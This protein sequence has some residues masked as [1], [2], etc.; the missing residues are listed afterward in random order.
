MCLFDT[1][2]TLIY[3]NSYPRNKIQ[4]ILYLENKQFDLAF[5]GSSRTENNIDCEV[6]EKITGKSCINLGMAGASMGDIYYLMKLAKKYNLQFDQVYLQLDYNYNHESLETTPY[7]KGILA[8]YHKSLF[9]KSYIPD[10]PYKDNMNLYP[11]YRY[12]KND[13]VIGF[14]EII[15]SSFNKKAGF[16]PQ[17]GF[18]PQHGNGLLIQGNLP[19]KIIKNN[20]A[21]EKMKIIFPI[22]TKFNLFTAPYCHLVNNREFI[23]RLKEQEP[24]LYNFVR[25]FDKK[26][27]Y[28][29]NC[30]HLNEEGAKEFSKILGKTISK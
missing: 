30:G 21:I 29:S 12:M 16:N 18:V 5:F 22:K 10:F 8:P 19:A 2:Y 25:I 26:P 27:K 11:F 14:R 1:A 7:F 23:D 13:K 9:I 15:F 20:M 3:R 28:F 17:N 24:T 4:T 6:I